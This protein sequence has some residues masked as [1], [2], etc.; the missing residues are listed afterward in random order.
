M[1][2]RECARRLAEKAEKI[3]IEEQ[4]TKYTDQAKKEYTDNRVSV[5][6][7]VKTYTQY[8]EPD[9]WRRIHSE[10]IYKT[11]LDWGMYP[12]MLIRFC[13][14]Y[15][16]SFVKEVICRVRDKH[17]TYFTKCEPVN[18]QRGKLCRKIIIQEGIKI[19]TL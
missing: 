9:L 6:N 1:D 17:E 14:E 16:E 8:T 10:P 7:Q 19:Y 12:T 13:K 3:A 18:V 2:Y 15:G 11:A 5:N 4:Y